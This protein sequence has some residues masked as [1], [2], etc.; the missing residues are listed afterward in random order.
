MVQV[1]LRTS[2]GLWYERGTSPCLTGFWWKAS[3]RYLELVKRMAIIIQIWIQIKF[4]SLSFMVHVPAGY[5]RL[6]LWLEL[7]PDDVIALN[8]V[9]HSLERVLHVQ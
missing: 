5:G 8:T 4:I 9:W 7:N 1:E 3:L 2:A 6:E